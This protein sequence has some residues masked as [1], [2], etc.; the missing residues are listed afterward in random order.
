M[1][2]SPPLFPQRPDDED[3]HRD[4]GRPETKTEKT[5][6]DPD[7]CMDLAPGLWVTVR[8]P[9]PED[10]H[11]DGGDGGEETPERSDAQIIR[12]QRGAVGRHQ[13]VE[14]AALYDHDRLPVEARMWGADF[15]DV[16]YVSNMF[17]KRRKDK[18]HSN[19][20][21]GGGS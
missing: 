15:V 13:H 8:V 12:P 20:K 18:E 7:P 11:D 9:D 2:L 5:E 10:P 16:F 17:F 6:N 21:V 3:E 19:A 1:F 4:H 14:S